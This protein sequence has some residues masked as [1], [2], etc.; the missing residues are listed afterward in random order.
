MMKKGFNDSVFIDV[1]PEIVEIVEKEVNLNLKNNI[2][3]QSSNFHNSSY[4]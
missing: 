1:K 2:G 3:L 4:R